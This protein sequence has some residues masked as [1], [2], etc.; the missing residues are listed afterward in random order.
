MAEYTSRSP[1]SEAA[2]AS[3]ES[4]REDRPPEG[5]STAKTGPAKGTTPPQRPDGWRE[6]VE[7]VVVAFVLAFL[8]RTFE[9]EAFVIPTGSM[10]PTLFGQHRDVDCEKCGTRFAVGASSRPAPDAEIQVDGKVGTYIAS[11]VRSQFAICPNANCR[12]PNNVLDREIFAGDRILVDKFPY[13]FGTPD[14]FDVVVFK[15]PEGAKTNY[16][17]RLVGLPGEDI[18]LEGGDVKV[19]PLGADDEV[20]RIARKAP[21]KQFCLQLP[22]YDDDYPA[23]ELVAAG[24]PEAW[25]PAAGGGWSSDSEAR[26]YRVDPDPL[27]P[28]REHWLR[29]THY[30]PTS[31][32]WTRVLAGQPIPSRPAAQ[33]VRDFYAYNGRITAQEA[34]LAVG[35]GRLPDMSNSNRDNGSKWVGDLTVHGTLEVLA[36]EGFVTFELVEGARRYRCQF[37]LASGQGQFSYQ[38]EQSRDEDPFLPAGEKFDA[39][40][41][42]TGKYDVTFANV[43]DRLCAWVDGRLVKALE[44]DEGS[45][46]APPRQPVFPTEQDKSPVA[47]AAR[48]ARVRVSHLRIERDIYYIDETPGGQLDYDGVYHLQDLDDD[49]ED[50]FLMLGDNSPR[51]NDSRLWS[52]PF[53]A[54][55]LLIGK[56]F[57]IY[58]PHGVPFMNNGRGYP[59]PLGSYSERADAGPNAKVP[60]PKMSLP[61]YP[62]AG[63]MHRI[64]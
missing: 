34:D 24:W 10:A 22:V 4:A 12:F 61:F 60:L 35:Q 64:R 7:S 3:R 44:F 63:R 45:R 33:E 23:R 20:F 40:M 9:A 8:F 39:R 28:D 21:E 56:A 29:Y 30:V 11:A 13:E 46:Y 17:K 16:I 58:W 25:A 54:R 18:R 47:I 62:Q 27:D 48:G 15:Y 42:S 57:F 14:R 55:R 32:V 38:H 19:R 41:N 31:D 6:T 52:K 26:A 51:S 2:P 5:K 53:V 49:R 59:L 1:K 43:D 36:A 37:D 50:Q